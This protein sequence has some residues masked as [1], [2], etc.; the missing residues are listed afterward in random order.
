MHPST[1]PGQIL[2]VN[3][4]NRI[5]PQAFQ[6]AVAGW[7]TQGNTYIGINLAELAFVESSGLGALVFGYKLAQQQGGRLVLFALQP[8]IKKLVS[9]T[10]LDRVL[11][12]FDTEAEAR[13]H[14][15][16]QL[17]AKAPLPAA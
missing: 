14:L 13:A 16:E 3:P 2:M 8:Y 10:K 11:P 9:V 1:Q 5:E 15:E 17:Q 4:G 12:I 6:Q 7:M